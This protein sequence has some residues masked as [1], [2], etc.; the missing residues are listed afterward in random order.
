MELRESF[1]A[2]YADLPLGLRKEVILVMD[3]EPITWNVAYI[4]V[5]N[6]TEKSKKILKELN[7]M[8]II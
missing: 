4:E 5:F 1:L 8:S 7:E 6:K 3:K 2:I